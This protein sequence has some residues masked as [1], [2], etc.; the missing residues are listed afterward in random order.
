[1]EII[2]KDKTGKI[3]KHIGRRRVKTPAGIV[4]QEINPDTGRWRKTTADEIKVLRRASQQEDISHA[5]RTRV[6]SGHS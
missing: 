4:L 6:A 2:V 3:K 1:M 5:R